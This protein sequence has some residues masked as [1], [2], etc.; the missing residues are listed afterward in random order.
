MGADGLLPYMG[1]DGLLAFL[2]ATSPRFA[3][4]YTERFP[5]AGTDSPAARRA[6]KAPVLLVPAPP[7]IADATAAD[8]APAAVESPPAA[9][10]VAAAPEAAPYPFAPPHTSLSSPPRSPAPPRAAQGDA[11][12]SALPPLPDIRG[13]GCAPPRSRGG[14]PSP[15]APVHGPLPPERQFD[16]M[17]F[18]LLDRAALRC[19]RAFGLSLIHI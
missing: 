12:L 11:G 5:P 7:S 16:T 2:L 6:L 9:S 3:R 18:Q 19:D 13:R 8:D 14:D 1:A 15:R 10:P 4:A 17:R